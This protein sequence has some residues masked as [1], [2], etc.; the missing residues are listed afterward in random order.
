MYMPTTPR[1]QRGFTLIELMITVV[2][3]GILAGI[4]LP[5]YQ[6]SVRKS[7]RSAA[8][9]RAQAH[10][11]R[12]GGGGMCARVLKGY[13]GCGCCVGRLHGLRHGTSGPLKEVLDPSN[14]DAPKCE[15]S[16][17]ARGLRH[18]LRGVRELQ[19]RHQHGTHCHPAC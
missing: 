12:G 19:L 4:A 9:A 3:I 8:Q 17:W 16:S 1:H 15:T 18:F 2:I 14:R 7:H 5:G 6:N 10:E 11:G 13:T